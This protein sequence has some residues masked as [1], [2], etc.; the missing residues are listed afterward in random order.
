[1]KYFIY[2]ATISTLALASATSAKAND[3]VEAATT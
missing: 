3:E 1:M 2:A